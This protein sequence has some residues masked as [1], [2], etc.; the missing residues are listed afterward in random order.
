MARVMAQSIPSSFAATYRSALQP[1]ADRDGS[2][3]YSQATYKK[4]RY[5]EGKHAYV[6][7]RYPFRLPQWQGI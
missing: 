1:E 4:A 7:R 5:H 3:T 6:R 2:I